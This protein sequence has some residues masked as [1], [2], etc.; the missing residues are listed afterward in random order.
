MRS[1]IGST[2]PGQSEP[3]G[4]GPVVGELGL[5][6]F[7]LRQCDERFAQS[8]QLIFCDESSPCPEKPCP[9]TA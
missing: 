4:L 7:S 2:A 9:P 3:T 1:L 5:D 8:T 6:V